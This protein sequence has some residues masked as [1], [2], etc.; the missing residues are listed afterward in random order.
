MP[1]D[2]LLKIE[3]VCQDGSCSFCDN[4]VEVNDEGGMLAVEFYEAD[5]RHAADLRIAKRIMPFK[6]PE[7]VVLLARCCSECAIDFAAYAAVGEAT[8]ILEVDGK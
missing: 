7:G 4:A 3:A 2:P 8:R 5:R 1:L 6:N